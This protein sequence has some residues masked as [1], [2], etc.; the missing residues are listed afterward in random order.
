MYQILHIQPDF[1]VVPKQ[2]KTVQGYRDHYWLLNFQE[3]EREMIKGLDRL[4]PTVKLLKVGIVEIVVLYN[5]C[6]KL[7]INA[8]E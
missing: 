3:Q 8:R 4:K 1:Y 7:V 6:G 5:K 2:P